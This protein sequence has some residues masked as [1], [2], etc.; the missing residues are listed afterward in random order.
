[1]R[2]GGLNYRSITE[3]AEDL[4]TTL[5]ELEDVILEEDGC[6]GLMQR[7]AMHCRALAGFLKNRIDVQLELNREL[8]ARGRELA[9]RLS[10]Q[11]AA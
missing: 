1:M 6:R 11:G 3:L 10:E 4:E 8:E 9:R 2:G 7:K 5:D